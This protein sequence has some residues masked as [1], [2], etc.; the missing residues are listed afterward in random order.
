MSS[1]EDEKK[2]L[3]RREA[4]K[5]CATL[6]LGVAAVVVSRNSFADYCSC[7]CET[8]GYCS[9]SYCSCP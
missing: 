7:H 8:D 4:L 2:I 3:S 6:T 5:R 9:F 1:Q